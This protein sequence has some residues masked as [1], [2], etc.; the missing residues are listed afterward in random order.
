MQFYPPTVVLRHRKENLKKCSLR[1]LESRDDFIFYTYPKDTVPQLNDYI[2]LVMDGAPEVSSADAHRGLFI[3]DGTWRYAEVMARQIQQQTTH[4]V[5][6]TLPK[7][8]R[9]AY[10]RKQEDCANPEQGLAS[11][12]AAYIAYHMMG[13]A[14]DGLLD[15]YHW[16]EAFLSANFEPNS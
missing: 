1:G 13:R 5:R 16:R 6:R 9:T 8:F 14:T 3:L 7:H 11:V 2:Y 10:P 12:E 4:C 15:K